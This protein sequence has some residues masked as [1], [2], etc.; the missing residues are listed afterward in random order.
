[1]KK[2]TWFREAEWPSMTICTQDTEVPKVTLEIIKKNCRED[3]KA[4]GCKE[5]DYSKYGGDVVIFDKR[6]WKE[7]GGLKPCSQT[8]R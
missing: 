1:M 4:R 6:G 5:V 3:L 2:R 7:L 8:N